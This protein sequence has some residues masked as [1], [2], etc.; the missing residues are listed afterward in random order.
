MARDDGKVTKDD[1]AAIL[2]LHAARVN[3]Y[4]L[5]RGHTVNAR[6]VWGNGLHG[7]PKVASDLVNGMPPRKR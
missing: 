7:W 1:L 2:K 6:V 3:A 4:W 5:A